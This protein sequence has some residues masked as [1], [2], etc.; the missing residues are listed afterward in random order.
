[1]A[2]SSS[3]VEHWLDRPSKIALDYRCEKF[4]E[5][6]KNGGFMSDFKRWK[7]VDQFTIYQIALLVEGHDP[8]EFEGVSDYNWREDIRIATAPMLTALCRAIGDGSL[9]L[10]SRVVEDEDSEILSFDASLVHVND[11]RKWLA[12]KG[13]SDAFF[14]P[15]AV[16]VAENR[17]GRFYAPKLA[18]AN[19][20]WTAVTADPKRLRGKSPKQALV[21]WLT[22]NAKEFSL[23]NKDGTANING[24]QEVAKVANWQPTGGAPNTPTIED[25]PEEGLG[26]THRRVQRADPEDDASI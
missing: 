14:M 5:R 3:C 8:A 26:K 25:E 13:I 9:R 18:A 7:I 2:R 17:P 15:A 19:A 23:L 12:S 22:E 6:I 20:A 11:L 16:E 4:D 1:M 21:Q 10:H 24:I